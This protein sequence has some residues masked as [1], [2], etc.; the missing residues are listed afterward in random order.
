[1]DKESRFNEIIEANRDRIFRICCSYVRDPD[2]RKDVFQEIIVNVWKSL[3]TFRAE[4][5]VTTW[6][7]RVVVNTCL[8]HLR[9]EKRRLKHYDS[10]A[11]TNI[12]LIPQEEQDERQEETHRSIEH[13]FRCINR[14]SPIDRALVAL[15]LEDVSSRESAE[16]LGIS[17]VN[18]RVKLH[19]IRKEL[20]RLM[21]EH[22]YGT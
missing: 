2:E 3:D 19:R 22:A 12:D 15:Y 21:K 4:S 14:L 10:E 1:M 17:E 7:Y 9:T 13:M 8:T 5:Q 6:V 18:I 16:I 20:K 11:S